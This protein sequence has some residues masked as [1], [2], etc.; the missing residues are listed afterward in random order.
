[1]LFF[2]ILLICSYNILYE[3]Q[4]TDYIGAK[5]N[6]VFSTP[7]SKSTKFLSPHR[8]DILY[9]KRAMLVFFSC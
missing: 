3:E 6:N 2:Y 1:M 5:L 4:K 8:T 9:S 7:L